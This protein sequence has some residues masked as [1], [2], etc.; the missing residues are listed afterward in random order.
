[1]S[2]RGVRVRV[3]GDRKGLDADVLALLDE[4]QPAM[5]LP[6]H[7]GSIKAVRTRRVDI[8]RRTAL[9]LAS[10]A[11]LDIAVSKVRTLTLAQELGLNVPRSLAVTRLEDAHAVISEVGFPLV[12]KPRDA[13]GAS[14]H[15]VAPYDT[16]DTGHG[17][18]DRARRLAARDGGSSME[19]GGTPLVHRGV[20]APWVEH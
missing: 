13:A 17:S 2:A 8:E 5:L 1:M 7:D 3:I 18:H 20:H 10:E 19:P 4:Q 14:V 16:A 15:R 6:A 11:A 12:I 9:A